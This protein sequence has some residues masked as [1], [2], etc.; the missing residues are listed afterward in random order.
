MFRW[1]RDDANVNCKKWKFNELS[2]YLVYNQCLIH[3]RLY[4]NRNQNQT[5]KF[6]TMLLEN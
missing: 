4:G 1:S 2:S 6:N 3:S 5:L